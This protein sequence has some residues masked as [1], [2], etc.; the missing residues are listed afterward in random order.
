MTFNLWTFLFE[1]IN[2][3]VLAYVLHRLLYRPLRQALDERREAYARMQ[4]EAQK[5]GQDAAALQAKLQVQQTELEQ[6][7]QQVAHKA[8]EQAEAERQKI[9]A[10][11][12]QAMQRRQEEVR[13]GLERE[14]EEALQALHAEAVTMAIELTERLLREACDST[15][16]RQ[17][18][19]RLAEALAHLPEAEC[20]QLRDHWQPDDGAVLETAAEL[21]GRIF[22]QVTEALAAVLG[23]K[24]NLVVQNRPA[25]LGGIRVRVGGHVWDASLAGQ[26]EGTRSGGVEVRGHA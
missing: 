25:L 12:E 7:R 20:T 11:A 3:V 9:L 24:V 26:L 2:F 15:L 6:Q 14:R 22:Q 10:E 4:A 13:Q 5:A 18:A 1:V 17:L 16:H 21:D 23:Q 8:Y 19:G